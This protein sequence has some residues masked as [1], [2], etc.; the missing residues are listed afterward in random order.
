MTIARRFNAGT[1]DRITRVPKGRLSR[2]HVLRKFP[3]PFHVQHGE[4][5][6]PVVGPISS[7]PF[8]TCWSVLKSATKHPNTP[9]I[10]N[11]RKSVNRVIG[12]PV[13]MPSVPFQGSLHH[14]FE[15][16]V[17]RLPAQLPESSVSYCDKVRR[18]SGTPRL[19]DD[20]DLLAG[21]MLAG[22]DYFTD[23]EARPVAQVK[24]PLFAGLQCQNM[25]LGEVSDVDKVPY[26]GAIGC[27]IVRS[28][29]FHAGFLTEGGLQNIR[30]EVSL[31]AVMFPEPLTRSGGIE[32]AKCRELNAVQ[33]AIPRKHL[34]DHQLRLTVGVDRLLR[35]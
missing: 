18:V 11:G 22:M 3:I 2:W 7:R 21:E 13:G 26:A 23:G 20:L 6:S 24:A 8:G 34:L 19:L 16:R 32:I 1:V 29:D 35:Q 14:R 27:W 31:N 15:G 30:N 17:S 25:R 28:E 12:I 10:R 9:L 4:T 5:V 33:L